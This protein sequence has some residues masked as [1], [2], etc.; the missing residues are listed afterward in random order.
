[1]APMQPCNL[2][3]PVATGFRKVT[4]SFCG[5]GFM[6]V[7]YVGTAVASGIN[8]MVICRQTM[9]TQNA[10]EHLAAVV[11]NQKPNPSGPEDGWS[12][13]SIEQIV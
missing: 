10:D 1:M 13:V 12:I 3:E 6:P 7:L 9:V 5:S 11:L 4:E 2:P 8:Y